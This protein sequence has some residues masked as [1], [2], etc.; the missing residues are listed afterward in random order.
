MVF[1]FNLQLDSRVNNTKKTFAVNK[2]V[3]AE[4]KYPSHCSKEQNA[5]IKNKLVQFQNSLFIEDEKDNSWEKYIDIDSWAR[6]Y[7]IDEIFEN[8]DACAASDC[9]YCLNIDSVL[10]AGP[11]WDYDMT[12]GENWLDNPNSFTARRLW[13]DDECYTPWYNLLWKK[14]K[15]RDRVIELYQSVCLPELTKLF[16]E[17]IADQTKKISDA[18]KNNALRWGTNWAESVEEMKSFLTKRV[19]FLN[20]AWIDGVD[21]KLI[22]LKGIGQCRFYCVVNGEKCEDLPSPKDFESDSATWYYEDTGT[23]F[24]AEKAITEDITLS[25]KQT[26]TES[27]NKI[28]KT[29]LI[30]FSLSALALASLFAIAIVVEIR[31]QRGAK[32]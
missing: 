12:L 5:A 8:L 15:F 14:E 13:K 18:A 24:D 11:C 30:F 16:N 25:A 6:K 32:K 19:A 7:L 23:V 31:H 22:T 3:A 1:F 26:I 21:Y 17:K 2:G 27:K 4:I 29:M 10:Y 20:S 28:T 9:F